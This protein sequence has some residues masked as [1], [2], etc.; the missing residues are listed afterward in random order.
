M[1]VGAVL[2]LRRMA[3]A[4][5]IASCCLPLTQTPA[6]TSR[7]AS[8]AV[9][10]T[11]YGRIVVDGGGYALYAFT[12]DHRGASRCYGACAKAWPPFIVSRRPRAARG[13]HAALIGTTRRRDGRIQATYRGRP[14]YYYVGDRRPGQ[15]LC[16]NVVEFGGRWLV[17]LASGRLVR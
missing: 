3:L 7:T 16:Q 2:M 4:L 14:L 13:T 6:S 15:V 5:G 1:A 12:R 9:R 11:A 8:I 10:S 17:L